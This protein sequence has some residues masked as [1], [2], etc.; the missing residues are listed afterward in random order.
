MKFIQ[1]LIN[2]FSQPSVYHF[3]AEPKTEEE[4]QR[5]ILRRMQAFE[6]SGGVS[7]ISTISQPS[8]SPNVS[9]EVKAWQDAVKSVEEKTSPTPTPSPSP[10]PMPSASPQY[11]IQNIKPLADFPTQNNPYY[12][13]IPSIW[14]NVN[15]VAVHNVMAGESS[16]RPNI[17]QVN[18]PLGDNFTKNI[19]SAE[20]LNNLLDRYNSVDLGL[21]QLNTAPALRDYVQNQGLTLYDLLDPT[22]NLQVAYDLYAGNIPETAPGWGNW[23]AAKNL[24]YHEY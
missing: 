19:N 16:F 22:T 13:D 6:S 11:K 23:Y 15:P 1:D 8:S 4:K 3:T 10:S 7:P 17:A 14:Q 2:R 5:E 20:E 21:M 12:G 9:G 24:G 18:V